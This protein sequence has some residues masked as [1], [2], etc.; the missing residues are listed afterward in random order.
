LYWDASLATGGVE[1][2][3]DLSIVDLVIDAAKTLD[4]LRPS[5][6]AHVPWAN[7]GHLSREEGFVLRSDHG[8]T[9]EFGNSQSRKSVPQRLKPSSV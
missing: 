4:E 3:S 6:S 5:F 9:D 1:N 7:M 2:T 8:D